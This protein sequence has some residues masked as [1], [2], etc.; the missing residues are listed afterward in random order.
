MKEHWVATMMAYSSGL[1]GGCGTLGCSKIAP[2]RGRDPRFQKNPITFSSE[3]VRQKFWTLKIVEFHGGSIS[4]T[5]GA[6]LDD[7]GHVF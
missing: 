2:P 6:I 3:G 7:L 4:G 1:A 5:F